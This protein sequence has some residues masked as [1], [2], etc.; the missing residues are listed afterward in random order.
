[1]VDVCALIERCRATCPIA[2]PM[3]GDDRLHRAGRGM[4]A[5]HPLRRTAGH[6]ATPLVGPASCGCG[7]TGTDACRCGGNGSGGCFLRR[8]CERRRDRRRRRGANGEAFTRLPPPRRRAPPSCEP[9]VHLRGPTATRCSASRTRT[10]KRPGRDQLGGP[11]S[12]NPGSFAGLFE[13]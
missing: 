10:P 7:T 12:F 8:L 1:M 11:S 6:G 9:T 2:A 4:G 5:R 3:R 13:A